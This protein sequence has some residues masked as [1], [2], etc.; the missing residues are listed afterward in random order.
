M[1]LIGP[2]LLLFPVPFYERLMHFMHHVHI[3]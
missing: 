2:E 1:F 3:T